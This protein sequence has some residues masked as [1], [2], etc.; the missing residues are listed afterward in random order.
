MKKYFLKLSILSILLYGC[1][2]SRPGDQ[3]HYQN[4]SQLKLKNSEGVDYEI[5]TR[6][7]HSRILITAFHGGFI[8]PGSTEL[9][10]AIAKDRF[11]FY[12]FK[13]LKPGL[14]H[15][16][17]YTSSSLH[18][19]SSRF[20]EPTLMDLISKKDFCLSLHGF[21]GQEADLCVGGANEKE[22]K[23]LVKILS[24]NYPDLKTCELCCP[25]FNGVSL[26]NP[27]NRCKE[28]GVQVEMSPSVRKR[29]LADERFKEELALG[30][31][32]FLAQVLVK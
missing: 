18:L 29:I 7:N 27:I 3:D 19:T 14:V 5:I 6:D 9:S 31:S 10:E 23:N 16:P 25:P 4:F 32:E 17:S 12:T 8:E 28:Q 26:K 30:F 15:K 2:S 20:D 22:R 24:T 11:D 21:G 13:A 1:A